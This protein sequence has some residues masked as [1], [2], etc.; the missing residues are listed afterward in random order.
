MR[1]VLFLNSGSTGKSENDWCSAR[2]IHPNQNISS[3]DEGR[4]RGVLTYGQ[5]A[6]YT[7]LPFFD[8]VLQSR[9]MV[10]PKREPL[11]VDNQYSGVG[12]CLFEFAPLMMHR[13][14]GMCNIS[15]ISI[16]VIVV[17]S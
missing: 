14:R 8:R 11:R 1:D 6:F 15:I 3:N 4:Y 13:R 16:M 17:Q 2:T 7:R 5:N 9:K 10:L 12:A